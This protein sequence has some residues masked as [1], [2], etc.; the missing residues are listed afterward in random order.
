[1]PFKLSKSVDALKE[2]EVHREL[3]VLLPIVLELKSSV[4]ILVSMVESVV[5]SD[6]VVLSAG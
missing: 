2:Q 6:V 5:L 4:L 3:L 1:M